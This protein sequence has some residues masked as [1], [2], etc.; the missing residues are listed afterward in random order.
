MTSS[1]TN[2]R[3]PMIG[4]MLVAVAALLLIQFAQAD[5]APLPCFEPNKSKQKFCKELPKNSV[6]TCD[7][8]VQNDCVGHAVYNINNFPDGAVGSA[9]GTTVE[10]QAD[11]WQKSECYWDVSAEPAK[12]KAYPTSA[13]FPGTKTVV[14][15][16]KCP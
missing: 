15:K 3:A 4:R 14:G 6:S 1:G 13:W 2:A 5:P 7:G 9:T 16:E 11:C 8:L 12:C 10:E